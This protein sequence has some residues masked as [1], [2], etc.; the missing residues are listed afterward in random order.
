MASSNS[1]NNWDHENWDSPVVMPY[2]TSNNQPSNFLSGSPNSNSSPSLN[3]VPRSQTSFNSTPRNNNI[4]YN[5]LASSHAPILQDSNVTPDYIGPIPGIAATSAS[6]FILAAIPPSENRSTDLARKIT[7]TSQSS[8][9]ILPFT[10]NETLG[11][12]N[13]TSIRDSLNRTA[14]FNNSS[15]GDI[16]NLLVAAIAST[17]TV[18]AGAAVLASGKNDEKNEMS[19]LASANGQSNISAQSTLFAASDFSKVLLTI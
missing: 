5:N 2:S 13:R 7:D 14:K 8:S 15:G 1:S 4:Q 19:N 10:T 18:G 12:G 16:N 3:H 17:A 9:E 11:L 6:P